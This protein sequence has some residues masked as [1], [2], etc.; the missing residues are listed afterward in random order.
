MTSNPRRDT[1][2]AIHGG[3][4]VRKALLPYGRQTLTEADVAAA[5]EV[6][7]SDWLTTGPKV[8]EFERRCAEM[9]GTRAAVAVNSGTAALVL[10]LHAL[11]VGPGDEVVTSPLTFAATLNAI[12]EVGATARFGDIG[13]D[14]NLDIDS[15]IGQHIFRRHSR[16]K[17]FH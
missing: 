7:R 17:H 11:E 14:F 5:T 4:P 9:A 6:L 8:A 16:L 15:E 13:D 3:P 12:L 10:A 2:L 1:P